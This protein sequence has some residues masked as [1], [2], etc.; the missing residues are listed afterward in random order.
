MVLVLTESEGQDL[1]P[2]LYSMPVVR[3]DRLERY[4]VKNSQI[5]SE[6][7]FEDGV[8]AKESKFLPSRWGYLS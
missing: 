4:L 8:V 1:Y 5:L 2:R 7:R 6:D 3:T